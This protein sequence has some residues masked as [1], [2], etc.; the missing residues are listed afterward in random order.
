MKPFEIALG[1]YNTTGIIGARHNAKIVKYFEAIGSGWVKDDDTSWCAC[2][3]NWCLMKAGKRFSSALNARQFLKYGVPTDR[4]VLGDIVVLWRISPTSAFGH[5]AFYIS[6]NTDG[7]INLLGGN[8][9]NM[10]T[11]KPFP[12][13]QVLAYRKTL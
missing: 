1:E 12:K 10:V 5:V 9:S 7:T 4:P 2:F 3:M 8:Q 13:T 11:I 6:A